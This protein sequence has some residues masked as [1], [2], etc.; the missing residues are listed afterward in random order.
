MPMK[1][2]L[3]QADYDATPE[4]LRA[5]YVSGS[6]A[7]TFVIAIEGQHPDL[8][9]ANMKVTEFRDNNIRLMREN[10]ALAK[11]KTEL[12][13]E[14]ATLKATPKPDAPT[15]GATPGPPPSPP[16]GPPPAPTPAVDTASHVEELIQRA[17]E[18][19]TKPLAERIAAKDQAEAALTARLAAAEFEKLVSDVALAHGVRPG[20]VEDVWDRALKAGFRWK[21]GTVVAMDGDTL[22]YSAVR[23]AE[24]LS[25]GEWMTGLAKQADHLFKASVGS[26]AAPSGRV[27]VDGGVLVNPSP[28]DFGKHAEAIASGK[29][30]VE[31]R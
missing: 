11:T 12:D 29:M 14:L 19:A 31:S 20:A 25:L 26:G 4:A 27:L 13:A 6:A 5:N 8:V 3:S 30:K 1:A 21:D 22:R 7:D 28:L 24:P 15:P 23:P 17:V 16:P 2:V 18:A 10:E 9:A